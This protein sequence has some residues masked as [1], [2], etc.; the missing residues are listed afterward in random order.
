MINR[1]WS[2]IKRE[3]NRGKYDRDKYREEPIKRN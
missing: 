1:E 3:M 2:I